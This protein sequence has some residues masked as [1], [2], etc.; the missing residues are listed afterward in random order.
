MAAAASPTDTGWAVLGAAANRVAIEARTAR[1]RDGGHPSTAIAARAQARVT[2][3]AHSDPGHR[4]PWARK[5]PTPTRAVMVAN[6]LRSGRLEATQKPPGTKARLV[7]AL[8][9]WLSRPVPMRSQ[10]VDPNPGSMR[11]G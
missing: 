5:E 6:S 2:S 9:G 7:R 8:T 10:S 1:R 3:W 11:T 4:G